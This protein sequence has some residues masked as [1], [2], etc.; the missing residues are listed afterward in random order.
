MIARTLPLAFLVIAG[1]SETSGND[2]RDADTRNYEAISAVLTCRVNGSPI[3]VPACLAANAGPVGGTLK[4]SSGRSTKR[5]T[6][7]DVYQLFRQSNDLAVRIP[8]TVPFDIMAQANG[9]SFHVLRVE[10]KQGGQTIFRDEAS[11]FD[12]IA[13]HSDELE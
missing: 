9:E 6:D 1:C 10:I 13:V 12:V 3:G 5:Y 7:Y 8:L 2:R 11:E 4:I